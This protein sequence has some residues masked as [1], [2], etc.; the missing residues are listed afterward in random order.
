MIALIAKREF[1]EEHAEF[2]NQMIELIKSKF[3]L[4][5]TLLKATSQEI[6]STKPDVNSHQKKHFLN[7]MNVCLGQILTT[8]SKFLSL[9]VCRVQ[10]KELT[11]E[12]SI[13][14]NLS[15]PNDN[16]FR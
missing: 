15:L 14:L 10:N 3:I 11:D 16:R 4:G 9:C 2:V 12:E 1:P 6:V 7:C 8:L 13:N 5:I